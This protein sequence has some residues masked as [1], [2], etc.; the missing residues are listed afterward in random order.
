MSC[1][2]QIYMKRNIKFRLLLAE[3]LH[4]LLNEMFEK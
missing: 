2:I 3:I 4:D 1:G